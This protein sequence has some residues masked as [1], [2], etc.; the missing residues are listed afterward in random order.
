[1]KSFSNIMQ[2]INDNWFLIFAAIAIVSVISIK[3]YKFF[4]R[5]SSEQLRQVQEWLLY[6]VA[7]A[8]EK[9]GSGTGE[10]K[11][12]YVYDM[13]V[14]KF[15]LVAIFID[16]DEF[17]IMVEKALDKFEE[18]IQTNPSIGSMYSFQDMRGE[19]ENE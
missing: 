14:A 16:F 5:P 7:K 10:L 18:L 6:A 12:R 4:K 13:F 19:E 11:L 9:L 2:F 15:P 1:M 8:E 17:S 3:I